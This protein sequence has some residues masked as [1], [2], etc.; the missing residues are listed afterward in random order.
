MWAE[1]GAAR[2]HIIP[3][4]PFIPRSCLLIVIGDGRV[5]FPLHGYFSSLI[6]TDVVS[7]GDGQNVNLQSCCAP[8]L[9]SGRDQWTEADVVTSSSHVNSHVTTS[10]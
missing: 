4:L 8:S 5:F 6:H 7:S 10:L 3:S 2:V 9:Q 1:L